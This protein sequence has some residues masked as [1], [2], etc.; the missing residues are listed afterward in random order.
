MK[1]VET[2]M[3]IDRMTTELFVDGMYVRTVCLPQG[4]IAIGHI[5]KKRVI[6]ILSKGSLLI[7]VEDEEKGVTITAPDIFVTEPGSKK[8]VYAIGDVVFT[9]IVRTDK[10]TTKEAEE[11]V[12][13][14][15]NGTLPY[16][17]KKEL[18]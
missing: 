17:R 11:D 9:N 8:T 3:D 18:T 15:H 10:L 1:L 16:M 12:V 6:N 5:H 4:T 14:P 2:T 7:K 13:E